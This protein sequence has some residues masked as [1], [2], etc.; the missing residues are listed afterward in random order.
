MTRCC[1]RSVSQCS[2]RSYC[3]RLWESGQDQEA[4]EELKGMVRE[5]EAAVQDLRHVM[6]DLHAATGGQ[7][8]SA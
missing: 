7:V 1:S 5:I 2:R 3:R 8:R 6:R 4:L